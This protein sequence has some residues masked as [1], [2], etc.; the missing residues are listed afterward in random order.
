MSV[1]LIVCTLAFLLLVLRSWLLNFKRSKLYLSFIKWLLVLEVVF[2][3]R[4][5]HYVW[6]NITQFKSS[7]IFNHNKY[8]E[9]KGISCTLHRPSVIQSAYRLLLISAVSSQVWARVYLEKNQCK[10]SGKHI[11]IDIVTALKQFIEA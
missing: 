11:L 8:Y 5:F 3:V 1:I 6:K 2:F 4:I 10:L 9:S 7:D